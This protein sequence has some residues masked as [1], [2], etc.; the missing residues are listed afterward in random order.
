V[1]LSAA[2][3]AVFAVDVQEYAC[4]GYKAA[5]AHKAVDNYWYYY[6]VAVADIVQDYCCKFVAGFEVTLAAAVAV[7]VVVAAVV[8]AAAVVVVVVAAAAVVVVAAALTLLGVSTLPQPGQ[9]D[10]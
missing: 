7:A 4:A 10:Q 2:V 5:G 9:P 1:G 6:G 3:D 8:V